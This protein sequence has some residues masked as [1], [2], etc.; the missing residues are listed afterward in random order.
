MN[1]IEYT[2]GDAAW[3]EI[4]QPLWE[5]LKRHHEQGSRHFAQIYRQFTFEQRL[6]KFRDSGA[7]AF[8]VELARDSGDMRLAGYCVS[9]VRPND[10]GEID[11]LY[12]DEPYRGAGIADTL[13]R[14]GLDWLKA[15]GARYI[16]INVAAGNE[17]VLSFYARYGFYPR[18]T[19]LA[20]KQVPPAAP[21]S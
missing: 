14:R 2:H 12:V 16:E 5:K 21:K 15:S 1:R 3:L 8:R 10:T 17:S 13:M 20:E 6:Q 9:M 18:H 4:I 7:S 11:S 19:T